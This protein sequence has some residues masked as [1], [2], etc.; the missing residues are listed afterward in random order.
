MRCFPIVGLHN[1]VT[2]GLMVNNAGTTSLASLLVYFTPMNRYV[3]EMPPY[4]WFDNIVI[5]ELMINSC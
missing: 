4:R 2:I 5:I 1:I 3:N